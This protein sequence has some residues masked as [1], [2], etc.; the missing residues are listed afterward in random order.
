MVIFGISCS[1]RSLLIVGFLGVT[2][3]RYC[4]E[5]LLQSVLVPICTL[6]VLSTALPFCPAVHSWKNASIAP[7]YPK[8]LE[9]QSGF[10]NL[11][12]SSSGTALALDIKKAEIALKD[13]NTMVKISHLV[14][15]DALAEKLDEF[16][17]E[18]RDVGRGLQRLGS[19]VG[20]AVDIYAIRSLEAITPKQIPSSAMSLIESPS[21]LVNVMVD[22]LLGRSW[23]TKRAQRAMLIRTFNLA[24]QEMQS[25]LGRLIVEAEADLIL[26]DRLEV[27]LDTIHSIVTKNDVDIQVKRDE[28]LADLWTKLGGNRAKLSVFAAHRT[29]LGNVSRFRKTALMRVSATILQLRQ[30]STDLDDLRDRVTAPS[31]MGEQANGEGGIPIEVHIESIRKGVERLGEYRKRSIER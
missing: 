25:Q 5:A 19:R 6:P 13:L 15:K 27:M 23:S 18:A 30:L 29:L 2:L 14:C 22:T 24:A 21:S 31:I 4:F 8:L 7:D 17:G 3:F 28:V 26:L 16:V 20:G 11:L 10:E 12:E 9:L 1:C